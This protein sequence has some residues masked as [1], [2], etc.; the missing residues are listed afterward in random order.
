[1]VK[2]KDDS[3]KLIKIKDSI[4]LRMNST[5]QLKMNSKLIR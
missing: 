5:I 1:M 3:F 4:Q 2:I